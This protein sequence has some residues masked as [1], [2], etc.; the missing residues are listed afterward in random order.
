MQDIAAGQV[1]GRRDFCPAGFLLV[2]LRPHQFS[3][4]QPKLYTG[5]GM[6]GIVDAAVAGDEASQHLTVGRID[7][8]I[9]AQGGN[10]SLPKIDAF[11][12]LPQ[13]GKLGN[14]LTADFLP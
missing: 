12:H 14:P 2:P 7:D 3:A 4:G 1:E 6:D 11:L 10:I 13:V 9:A 8:R 5:E